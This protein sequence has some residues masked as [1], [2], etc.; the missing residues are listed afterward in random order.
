M[1][2]LAAP[3]GDEETA[4]Q[5]VDVAPRQIAR[6]ANVAREATGK[7]VILQTLAGDPDAHQINMDLGLAG[8]PRHLRA[9]FNRGLAELARQNSCPLFD[10]TSHADLVGQSA[11]SAARFW[12][13]A[14]YPFAPVM[15]PLY[16]DHVARR[17][18]S[19][20][21]IGPSPSAPKAG[22]LSGKRRRTAMST[23]NR[24]SHL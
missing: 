16:A 11:W 14:K 4:K 9:E 21:L 24:V 17:A 22:G 10:A 15:I 5:A 18:F 13:A 12:Y 1:L 7:C 6:I 20:S 8:T 23:S 2:K 19:A 3:L